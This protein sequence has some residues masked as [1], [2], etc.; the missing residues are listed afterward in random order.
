[1]SEFK[2]SAGAMRAA[3][4]LDHDGWWDGW[5]I[6][7]EGTLKEIAATIDQETG[8]PDLMEAVEITLGYFMGQDKIFGL[9]AVQEELQK[10]LV[11]ARA[12]AKGE[13]Q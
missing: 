4:K 12:K 9:T 6:K 11:K 5:A 13:S 2:Y 7:H 10:I 1:M 3:R 8:L